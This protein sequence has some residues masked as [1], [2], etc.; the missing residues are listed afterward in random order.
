MIFS[1]LIA[2]LLTVAALLPGVTARKR[3]TLLEILILMLL[4]AAPLSLARDVPK[5]QEIFKSFLDISS[6]PEVLVRLMMAAV[7]IG[8]LEVMIRIGFSL[9][10]IITFIF[11]AIPTVAC[12]Q[13]RLSLAIFV[14]LILA[15]CLRGIPGVLL[16]SLIH[17]SLILQLFMPQLNENRRR[18]VMRL[19]I[20]FLLCG[21]IIIN[22][23]SMISSLL[24]YLGNVATYLHAKEISGVYDMANPLEGIEFPFFFLFVGLQARS[25][26]PAV[27]VGVV[28]GLT[29]LLTG[30]PTVITM[31]FFEL[32]CLLFLFS[33]L[34]VMKIRP[35]PVIMFGL[36]LLA[37]FYLHY[38]S[39]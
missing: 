12:N 29:R 33:S 22:I 32:F 23:R 19:I 7:F 37:R 6:V 16:A 2:V 35:V 25:V 39:L 11:L 17:Q 10:S 4:L 9:G 1:Y 15:H 27:V 5:Y 13:L 18:Y 14:M 31:R 3:L 8:I 26:R 34:R 24:P 28:F 36:I 20:L 38:S 21:V 30:L